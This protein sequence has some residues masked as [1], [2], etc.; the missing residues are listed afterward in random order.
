MQKDMVSFP[1][2]VAVFPMV[3]IMMIKGG[4]VSPM[5]SSGGTLDNFNN[6]EI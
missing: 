3:A 4:E 2:A 1:K 5:G 6:K